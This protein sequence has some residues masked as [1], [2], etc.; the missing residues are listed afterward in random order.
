VSQ[1]EEHD[2]GSPKS[3]WISGPYLATSLE[4]EQTLGVRTHVY[5]ERKTHANDDPSSIIYYPIGEDVAADV[6][7]LQALAPGAPILVL[8]FVLE[9]QLARAALFAGVNGFIH[10]GMQPEQIQRIL[11]AVSEGEIVVSRGIL[12]AFLEEMMSWGDLIDLT[13]R[14]S[15][16]LKLVASTSISQDEIVIPRELLEAF[17]IGA[18]AA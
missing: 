2:F 3:V 6:R 1:I 10:R 12:E 15:D 7:C 18:P 5:E 17:M 14:Q 4:L 11:S 16:F 8:S 9:P 13:P